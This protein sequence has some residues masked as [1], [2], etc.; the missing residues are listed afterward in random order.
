MWGKKG[1]RQMV[2][3]I[4]GK[5]FLFVIGFGEGDSNPI[6]PTYLFFSPL[7]HSI[8]SKGRTGKRI[9]GY[10]SPFPFLAVPGEK[11]ESHS[12]L[13]QE[14]V[15]TTKIIKLNKNPTRAIG[16]KLSVRNEKNVQSESGVF[17]SSSCTFFFGQQ[18]RQ[19]NSNPPPSF[20]WKS[21]RFQREPNFSPPQ[22]KNLWSHEEKTF[23]PG[24]ISP[25]SS[26]SSSLQIWERGERGEKEMISPL[27][28]FSFKGSGGEGRTSK[29]R[30]CFFS[31]YKS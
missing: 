30:V 23:F 17:A 29:E 16:S 1:A 7:I 27:I 14:D 15:R 21:R 3:P 9:T 20:L 8:L 2:V 24:A 19:S 10:L 11:L 25:S 13:P 12:F 5:D 28:T 6:L 26:F 18:I 4:K 22:K 31:L